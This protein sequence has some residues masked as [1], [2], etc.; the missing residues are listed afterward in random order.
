MET[1]MKVYLIGAGP[2]DPGLLTL[3]GRAALASADAVVYDHLANDALLEAARPDAERIYVGKTGGDHTLS[4]S[5]INRLLVEKAREGKIVARLKG[6]DPYVFGRGGEEAEELVAAGI[7]FEEIP[8]VTSAIAAPA[9]AGIPVTHRGLSSSVCFITGHEDPTKPESSHDWEALA[10][11]ASTLVFVMGVKNLPRISENLVNAGMRPDMPAALVRWGTTPMHESLVST[12]GAIAEEAAAR[13]I[14]PPCVLVVGEVVRLHDR[15]NWFERKPLLGKGI[16]VTRSRE[17]AGELRSRLEEL[18]A[19]V[20]EFPTI[21]VTPLADGPIKDAVS[22]LSEYDWVVFTSANGVD[23]FFSVLTSMGRDARVFSRCRIAAMGAGT[24]QALKDRAIIPD[25]V[26]ERFI[27]ESMAEGLTAKGMHGRRVLIPRARAARET[28]PEKLV[29]AGAFVTVLPV[30]ETLP[31]CQGKDDIMRCL[32]AGEA[33][34]V[35]FAS[36]STVRNFFERIP[37]QVMRA[38]PDVRFACIGPVTRATL[39]EFG[40]SASIEPSE[41]TIPAMVDAIESALKNS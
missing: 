35:T 8:G 18:G 13:R 38:F 34:C 6:G 10:R 26:P 30:Y 3:K 11:S 17:Q 41:Y 16:V 9:Y 21:A 33:Q 12:I 32:E 5:E 15:L 27:A 22:R 29:E 36:S 39:E 37:P 20:F 14:T 23:R 7:P 25:F 24:A 40:F 19:R 4:Q 2:G 31:V 1:M 28:L